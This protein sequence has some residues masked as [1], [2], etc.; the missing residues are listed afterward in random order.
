MISFVNISFC[1]FSSLGVVYF[2]AQQFTVLV[3]SSISPLGSL[4]DIWFLC[5]GCYF[6]ETI[7]SPKDIDLFFFLRVLA[8]KV[9]SF[10]HFGLTFVYGVGW[11]SNFI[12]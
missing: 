7:A 9:G 6:L 5:S 11:G 8:F 10:T 4:Y 1:G 12:F 3:Q 2:E